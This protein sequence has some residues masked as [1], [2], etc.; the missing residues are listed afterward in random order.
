MML[1]YCRI[2]LHDH[3]LPRKPVM[4]M[5]IFRIPSTIP[6][7]LVDI[8]IGTSMSL[9]CPSVNSS[10]DLCGLILEDF[11]SIRIIFLPDGT[12]YIGIDRLIIFSNDRDSSFRKS[13]THHTDLLRWLIGIVKN[14]W[15]PSR[16][17]LAVTKSSNNPH[18]VSQR[19]RER[20]LKTVILLH[21]HRM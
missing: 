19:C 10:M 11:T 20:L 13:S 2:L 21:V 18:Q 4:Y 12:S 7:F 6:M 1:F 3:S 5:G 17:G 14:R 8:I 9:P 16:Q 15:I